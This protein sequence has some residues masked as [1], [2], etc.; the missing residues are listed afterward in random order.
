MV[1]KIYNKYRYSEIRYGTE[2]I[3]IL[4]FVLQIISTFLF[5]I[6]I[7]IF[8]LKLLYTVVYV[9]KLILHAKAIIIYI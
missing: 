5:T 1:G 3:F 2:N 7:A 9:L 6:V 4:V 8:V